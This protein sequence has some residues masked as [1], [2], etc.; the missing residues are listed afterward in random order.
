VNEAKKLRA[1]TARRW[2]AVAATTMLAAAGVAG[3]TSTAADSSGG[4][5]SG[6]VT[7]WVGSWWQPKVDALVAAWNKDHPDITLDIQ[8]QPINNYADKFTAAALGGD[9]PDVIDLDVGMLS[10][11]AAQN[12][13]QPL[14]Q[15]VT[16]NKI[17]PTAYAKAVWEASSFGGTQYGMPDHAYSSFLYYN[18]DLFDKA[19]V[20]YP[21]ADWDYDT[22]LADAQ[23][24]T[25]DDMTGFGMAADLSDPANAM[26]WIAQNIWGHGGD[27]FNDDQTQA[28]INSP[29]AIAGLQYW[30]D[31]YT[32]YHVVPASTPNF[33]VTRDVVPLFEA[34]K[35]AMVS[36]GAQLMTEFAKFPDLNYGMVTL[37]DKVNR[38]GGWTMGI[39]TGAK[40]PEAA[41]VFLQWFSDPT[42][43]GTFMPTTP[44]IIASNAVDPWN[45]PQFD[46]STAA[47][48][49]SRSLPQVANWGPMQVAIVTELQKVLVGQETVKQAADSLESQLNDLLKS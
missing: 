48:A 47:Y 17:D 12:L 9:P 26:D 10:T 41:K 11:I 27:F 15:F 37:P 23:A 42:T 8:Q 1:R 19:G 44:G 7:I 24:L 21:T 20:A 49:D 28:T 34:G 35:V 3:C 29:E 22:F 45:A 6:T 30:A 46:V 43:Q 33:T 5:P 32:K 4:E 2:V 39:P 36:Q 25:K 16:D 31:L 14:D 40:N 18:K 38:G 13:L